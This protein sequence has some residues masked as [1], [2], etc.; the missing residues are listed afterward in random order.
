M[1]FALAMSRCHGVPGALG[2]DP[3]EQPHGAAGRAGSYLE[4]GVQPVDVVALGVSGVL[5]KPGGL[6][7]ALLE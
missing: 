6:A 3:I 1:C 4:F 7:D 5:T 2:L